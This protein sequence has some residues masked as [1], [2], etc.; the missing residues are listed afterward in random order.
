MTAQQLLD[1]YAQTTQAATMNHN[2]GGLMDWSSDDQ[3]SSYGPQ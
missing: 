3:F 2:S 1:Y